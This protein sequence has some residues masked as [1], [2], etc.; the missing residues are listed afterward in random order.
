MQT[1]LGARARQIRT[2][3]DRPRRLVRELLAARLEAV[4]EHLD[5]AAAA[6]AALLVLDL[7]LD[8]KG[9]VCQRD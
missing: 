2:E 9:F 7:V 1:D 5:V 4:L 3:H 6:V 8:N